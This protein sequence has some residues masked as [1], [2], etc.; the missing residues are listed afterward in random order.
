[1]ADKYFVEDENKLNDIDRLGLAWCRL[2]LWE[3]DEIVGPKP[4]GFDD[5]PNYLRKRKSI[6]HRN[7]KTV[8]KADYLLPVTKNIESIIGEANTSRCWWKFVL[9]KTEDEWREWYLR[10]GMPFGN[11]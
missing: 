6:F 8:T 3:W 10:E 1:M 9:G 7:Q 4:D 2:S 5:L 11:T